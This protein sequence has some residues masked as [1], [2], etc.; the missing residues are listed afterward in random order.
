MAGILLAPLIKYA[1]TFSPYK[2]I[3]FPYRIPHCIKSAALPVTK[4][5]AIDVPLLVAYPP[6]GAGAVM[7]TPGAAISGFT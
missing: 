4:G 1:F 2:K 5:V 6:P 7:F 3:S